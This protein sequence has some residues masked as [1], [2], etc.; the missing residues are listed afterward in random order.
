M[1]LDLEVTFRIGKK[2]FPSPNDFRRKTKV[3][4]NREERLS[5]HVLKSLADVRDI[6]HQV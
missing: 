3:K 6:A 1:V 2:P 4:G 5:G